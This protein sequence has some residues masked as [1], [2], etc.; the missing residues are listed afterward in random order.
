M[1]GTTIDGF[2]MDQFEDAVEDSIAPPAEPEVA[3]ELEQPRDADGRFASEA[4]AEE[5]PEAEPPA[6]EPE[7]ALD[8]A[9]DPNY[10][11]SV[12]LTAETF[13]E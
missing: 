13:A 4:P 2:P 1:S 11:A 8:E 5:T 10:L 3:A 12:G 9:V 6:E 7:T